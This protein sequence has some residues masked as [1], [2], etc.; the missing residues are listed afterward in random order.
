MRSRGFLYFFFLLRV[1]S[2]KSINFVPM[3]AGVAR[4]FRH[5]DLQKSRQTME[6]IAVH[7]I[8]V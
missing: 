3:A 6:D 1:H 2:V 8:V 4:R 5:F 7:V